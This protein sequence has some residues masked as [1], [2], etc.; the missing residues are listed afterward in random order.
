[1]PG[2]GSVFESLLSLETVLAC[3]SNGNLAGQQSGCEGRGGDTGGGGLG[4]LDFP[5]NL[6]SIC[7]LG[8]ETELSHLSLGT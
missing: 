6:Q 1:M 3:H 5:G 7:T 4:I 2:K 8:A